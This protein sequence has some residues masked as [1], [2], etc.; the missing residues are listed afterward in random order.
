MAGVTEKYQ[1]FKSNIYK[2]LM[3]QRLVENPFLEDKLNPI[4]VYLILIVCNGVYELLAASK[5][6]FLWTVSI[7]QHKQQHDSYGMF[8][9]R[10]ILEECR[11]ELWDRSSS[12]LCSIRASH[13]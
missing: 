8:I 3:K 10:H 5:W 13:V 9:P 7:T 2:Q 6:A 11:K 4:S 12:T 1:I